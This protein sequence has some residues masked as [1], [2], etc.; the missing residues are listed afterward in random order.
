MAKIE[1]QVWLVQF[2]HETPF[3]QGYEPVSAGYKTLAGPITVTF[4]V[5][6]ACPHCGGALPE[7]VEPA[8]A[9]P[10]RI[11]GPGRYR[12]RQ[13]TEAIIDG[14]YQGVGYPGFSWGGTES[15]TYECW[16]N[17]GTYD[18]DGSVLDLVERIS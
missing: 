16:R 17:D 3:I 18:Q 15:G 7:A 4:D 8:K 2:D 1:K 14:P 5:P 11:T 9:E 13:G 6:N 10:F 12:T